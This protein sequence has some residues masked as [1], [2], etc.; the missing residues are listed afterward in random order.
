MGMQI[1]VQD[2]PMDSGESD[3]IAATIAQLGIGG[4]HAQLFELAQRFV[5]PN[6]FNEVGHRGVTYNFKENDLDIMYTNG[7]ASD[8]IMSFTPPQE[9][10][11]AN[12][13]IGVLDAIEDY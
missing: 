13:I 9:T 10:S 4:N 12:R 7:D 8:V 3:R 1:D 11:I 6:G 5:E 2:T